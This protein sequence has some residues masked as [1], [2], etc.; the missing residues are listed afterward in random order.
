MARL[1]NRDRSSDEGSDISELY[2]AEQVLDS[3]NDPKP[4]MASPSPDPAE[5][6][7]TEMFVVKSPVNAT[8]ELADSSSRETTSSVVKVSSQE[9]TEGSRSSD[10]SDGDDVDC[11]DEISNRIVKAEQASEVLQS[12]DG[13]TSGRC[14]NVA[15]FD[16]GKEVATNKIGPSSGKVPLVYHVDEIMELQR[17]ERKRRRKRYDPDSRSNLDAVACQAIERMKVCAEDDRNL[18]EQGMIATN[19]LKYVSDVENLAMRA[20]ALNVMLRNDLLTAIRAWLEPLPDKSIPNARIRNAMYNILEQMGSGINVSSLRESGIGRVVMA[21]SKHPRE[22]AHNRDRLSRIINSWSRL[23]FDLNELDD[24]F[25]KEERQKRD[26][27]LQPRNVKRRRAMLDSNPSL[28]KMFAASRAD[29][30][31]SRRRIGVA[32]ERCQKRS[33][34]A[35]AAQLRARIPFP[36]SCDYVYRPTSAICELPNSPVAMRNQ[37][38]DRIK[39][40]SR[41]LRS[42]PSKTN[43]FCPTGSKGSF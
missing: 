22:T 23:I 19:K 21:L 24:A 5:K 34:T 38:L 4:C 25:S 13:Q 42:K 31:V 27:A 18:N 17:I 12:S 6:C 35:A 14:E 28:A 33:R 20:G 29:A 2:H 9:L 1:S 7:L 3:S 16:A 26:I 8:V 30:C 11:Y 32:P 43:N 36:A 40:I 41:K 37:K 10:K 15:R 39:R